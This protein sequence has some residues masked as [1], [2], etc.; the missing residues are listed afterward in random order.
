MYKYHKEK[1]TQKLDYISIFTDKGIDKT[2]STSLKT[3]DPTSI[4]FQNIF[5]DIFENI[6]RKIDTKILIV[7]DNIDRVDEKD[8]LKIWATMRTFLDFKEINYYWKKNLWLLIPF[9][10]PGLERL[11]KN[12]KDRKCTV[13]S[14]TEKTFQITFETPLPILSD[15]KLYFENQ[16]KH[17]FSNYSN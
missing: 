15:W 14:F 3:I 1:G 16:F 10:K 17:A 2:E 7:I 4:E 9:D 11:W 8:A 6:K 5:K 13:T 12:D